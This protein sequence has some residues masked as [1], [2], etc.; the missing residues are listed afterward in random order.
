MYAAKTGTWNCFKTLLARGANLGLVDH[1]GFTVLEHTLQLSSE[2][3]PF[4][5]KASKKN[6]KVLLETLTPSCDIENMIKKGLMYLFLDT[7]RAAVEGIVKDFARIFFKFI[8]KFPCILSW[9]NE[10]LA[11]IAEVGNK[12]TI[13]FLL[14]N[15][16][17]PTGGVIDRIFL[18]L[19]H[20]G[21][22][23]YF[24]INNLLDVSTIVE[25][26]RAAYAVPQVHLACQPHFLI[27]S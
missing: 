14:L 22:L 16:V 12:D 23:K 24:L 10:K 20:P 13:R 27:S 1:D 5:Y 19:V 4:L 9:C 6:L 15:G 3:N 21:V 7:N 11:R 25:H 17:K 26:H 2:H 8:H 18:P